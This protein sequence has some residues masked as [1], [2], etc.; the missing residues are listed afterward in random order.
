MSDDYHEI[1]D[2][3]V[4]LDPSGGITI[5][6]VTAEGDPVELSASQAQAL[7]DALIR[8]AA[9]D[10]ATWV[11]RSSFARSAGASGAWEPDAADG[12]VAHVRED[13]PRV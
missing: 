6:A 1:D 8:L 10:A 5:K 12:R 3:R 7:A 11:R 9:Q 4:W 2:V 13:V